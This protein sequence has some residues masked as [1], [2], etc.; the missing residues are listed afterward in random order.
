MVRKSTP[1]RRPTS[2]RAARPP[3]SAARGGLYRYEYGR[4]W[5]E[6]ADTLEFTEFQGTI[7]FKA[8]F[9][10]NRLTGCL[11]CVEPIETAPGRHLFPVVP[12]QGP[13]PAALPA[14][15]DLHFAASFDAR[16]SFEDTAITVTHTERAITHAAGT[17]RGQFSNVPDADGRPRRV[18]GSADVQ[19]A[20]SDGSRGSFTGI[21]DVLTPATLAPDDVD[22]VNAN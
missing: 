19:F 9:D 5:D 4:D 22:S 8:D 15:Y 16:G 12:W 10:H 13:D 21:F 1:L 3:T 17:W 2:L 18:V 7:S 11:G 6:L 14:D 20:E